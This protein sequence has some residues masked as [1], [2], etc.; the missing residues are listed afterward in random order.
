MISFRKSKGVDNDAFKAEI[1]VQD[2][3][4]VETCENVDEAVTQWETLVLDIVDKHMPIRTK[5]VKKKQSPWLNEFLFDLMKKR[6]KIKKRAKL[7]NK[8]NDWKEYR[9]M[10]NKVTFEIKKAKKQYY[11]D[12]I[13]E[14]QGRS[15]SWEILKLL[16]P[17]KSSETTH[18][19]DDSQ[20]LAS[21][22]N[23]H[24]A[25]VANAHA[26]ENDKSKRIPLGNKQ[27]DDISLK[28]SP[29]TEMDVLKE[30]FA[31]KNKK[32][33]GC[34]GISSYILK[35]CGFEIV[36]SITYIINKSICEGKVPERWKVAKITPLF[37]KGDKSNPD[38]Y[39]PISL[40]PCVSKVLER[41]IQ[42]QLVKFLL[43]NNILTKHQSG[44]RTMHSTSTTLIKVTDE[45]LMS[46]DNGLYTGTVFVDLQKAFD[47]VDLDILLEKLTI[48][49]GL[50]GKSLNW[51]H[52]YLNGRR[53]ATSINNT[54]SSELPVTHGV[55]QGSI[56]G[57]ILFLLFINDLPN[58]FEKC[59]VHLYADDTVIYFSDKDPNI[60]ECVINQE[61]QK[62]D[63]WMTSNKLKINCTKTVCMLMGTKHM[64]R[65]HSALNLRIKNNNLSQV[66]SF[67][68]LGVVIDPGLKWNLHIDEL[69]KKVGRMI[70]YLG[71][72]GKFV[73]ESSLKLLY[74]SAIMPHFD[75]SDVI[76]HSAAKT[77]LD[78]LQKLQNRA[79]RI[80]LKVKSCEHKS[81]NEIHDI[82]NWD[83]LQKRNSKHTYS[84][85]YKIL[86]DM[87]PEYLREKFTYK[88][89]CYSLRQSDNLTLPKPNTQNCKRTFLY[90]GSKLYNELPMNIRQSRSLAIFNK[91]IKMII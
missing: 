72:V 32:S 64:L 50:K 27:S 30:I 20:K 12:K 84:M 5:R 56:L 47:L 80:I 1:R 2:W 59:S 26:F 18:T 79:G 25:N 34:D 65:K 19:G 45:W 75:Y 6:D 16:I 17:S 10:R 31:L 78:M 21:K 89:S 52:S 14:S 22:F 46:L 43:D 68:Y 54:L 33:V 24:F 69:C 77:N 63:T 8:E 85:V 81:I 51:F 90:R 44:F 48:M 86:H 57:P 82:L 3:S 61:L 23:S 13:R 62:L 73:N 11:S 38:H 87:A 35:I 41:V 91:E 4:K 71:R 40:L 42:R 28:L 39:R 83:A 53:I 66:E 49:L 7:Y 37:K 88:S 15:Q 55:P 67:K 60:I 76:W 29:V 58:C 70:S 36:K 9:K 74:N